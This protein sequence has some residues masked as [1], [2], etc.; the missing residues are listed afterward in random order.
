[1][2]KTSER[3]MSFAGLFMRWVLGAQPALMRQP[4][5]RAL[6]QVVFRAALPGVKA[7]ERALTVVIF[8]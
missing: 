2:K 1:M 4:I 5:R 7:L 8:V 3:R 6:I